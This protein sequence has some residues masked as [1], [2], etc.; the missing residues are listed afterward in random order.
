VRGWAGVGCKDWGGA[1]PSNNVGP[2]HA[3]APRCGCKASVDRRWHQQQ[4]AAAA[5]FAGGAACNCGRMH[6]GAAPHRRNARAIATRCFSPPLSFR[7]RSPTA[8]CQPCTARSGRRRQPLQRSRTTQTRPDCVSASPDHKNPPDSHLPAPSHLRHAPHSGVQ[9]GSG[10][11]RRHLAPG[12]P[13][14]PVGDVVQDG[15]VEQHGVL[16]KYGVGVQSCVCVC[17][18]VGGWTVYMCV[19]AQAHRDAGGGC[20]GVL[21]AKCPVGGAGG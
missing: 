19:R 13:G 15:F 1:E 14:A 9:L 6:R 16:T 5:A 4:P 20:M 3:H 2:S 11:R 7:P 12:C 17:V 10:S 8:V 21:S 18:S